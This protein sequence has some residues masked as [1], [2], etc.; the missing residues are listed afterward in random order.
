MAEQSL[1]A[2]KASASGNG[3]VLDVRSE[4]G[5]WI[6]E[7]MSEA[8]TAPERLWFHLKCVGADS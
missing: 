1:Q 6:V 3:A 5:T 2:G 4:D 7:F 8:R